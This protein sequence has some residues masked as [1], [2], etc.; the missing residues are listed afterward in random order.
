MAIQKLASQTA[1]ADGIFDVVTTCGIR[2]QGVFV[3]GQDVQQVRLVRILA[4]IA[5]AYGYGDDLGATCLNRGLSF[6]HIFVF[7]GTYQES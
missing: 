2:Q 7:A 1:G 4:D 6:S 5:A 3:H